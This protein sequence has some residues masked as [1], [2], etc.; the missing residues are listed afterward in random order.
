MLQL[1][2]PSDFVIATGK[3]NS[4]QNF[5]KT[6][7]QQLDLKL[8]DHIKID[9]SLMRPNELKFSKADVSKATN[10]LGWKA[11]TFMQDV[12]KKMI[13]AEKKIIEMKRSC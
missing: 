7:F 10:V 12:I 4:L 8:E 2:T 9:N 13:I 1:K 5:A 6:V 11:K 3:T